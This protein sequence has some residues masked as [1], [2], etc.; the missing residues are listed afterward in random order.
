M[1]VVLI[2]IAVLAIIVMAIVLS[3]A[4]VAIRTGPR[5]LRGT[6]PTDDPARGQRPFRRPRGG[7]PNS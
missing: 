2:I 5:R 3:P 1:T 4:G 6:P 7:S